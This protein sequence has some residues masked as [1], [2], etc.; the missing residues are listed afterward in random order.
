MKNIKEF[1]IKLREILKVPKYKGLIQLA[2]WFIFFLIVVLLVRSSNSGN[3]VFNDDVEKSKQSEVNSYIY[4]YQINDGINIISIMGTHYNNE[5]TFNYNNLK[6]YY[7]DNKYYLVNNTLEETQF[8]ISMNEYMYNNINEL[9]NNIDYES[10]TEYKDKSLKYDY[11]ID[12]QTYNSFYNKTYETSGN[13]II[14]IIKNN[15]YITSVNIDLS[16]Y[17]NEYQTYIVTINYSNI[18]NITNLD[19]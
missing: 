17:L 18:N 15:D 4:N 16:N 6:Y 8:N 3:T 13:V 7:K 12:S 10:K 9:V 2:F 14:S 1:I 19:I 11:I 5:E